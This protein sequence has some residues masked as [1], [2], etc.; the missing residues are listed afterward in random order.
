MICKK[1]LLTDKHLDTTL[2]KAGVCNFCVSYEKNKSKLSDFA[3]LK[4]ILNARMEKGKKNGL[5]SEYDC[6][7]P[8]SGGKDSSYVLLK[9]KKEYNFRILAVTCDN[10]FSNA[11]T[12]NNAKRLC[13]ELG[14]KHVYYKPDWNTVRKFYAGLFKKE[15][16][17]CRGC[18]ALIWTKIFDIAQ[19]EKIPAVITGESRDQMLGGLLYH[20]FNIVRNNYDYLTKFS[21]KNF[22]W[23]NYYSKL[24]K[25]IDSIRRSLLF[26]GRAVKK[27]FCF[28][29]E[30]LRHAFTADIIPYF[31]FNKYDEGHNIRILEKETSWRNVPN[32]GIASHPDCLFHPF[33]DNPWVSAYSL[34]VFVRE[35]IMSREEAL[36]E[37]LFQ[38]L[39]FSRIDKK[40]QIQN[41]L[42]KLKLNF[43]DI[44]QQNWFK[45]KNAINQF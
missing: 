20:E 34:S 14:I 28:T 4:K 42:R 5:N 18:M 32:T 41:I 12:V 31:F 45:Q 6:I 19:K 8:L 27:M 1:C 17:I 2:N 10:G 21:E 39:A 35:G 43:E 24:F 44:K 37:N 23:K 29:K 38:L 13:K 33:V 11:I 16:L 26:Q 15:G 40:L 7:V 25:E 30:H 36:Q 3:K 9:M 22:L